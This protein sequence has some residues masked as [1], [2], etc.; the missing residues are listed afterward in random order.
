LKEENI[1]PQVKYYL[2][3]CAIKRKKWKYD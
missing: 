3:D 2:N 1:T